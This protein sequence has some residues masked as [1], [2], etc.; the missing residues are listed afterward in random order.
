MNWAT[1][2]SQQLEWHWTHQLR[3]RFQGLTDAEYL[4][5]PVAGCWSVRPVGNGKYMADYQMPEPSPPPVTTIAW[6]LSHIAGPVLAWRNFNHFQ[7]PAFDI[8]T[9]E[10]PGTAEAALHLIDEGYARWRAGVESLGEERLTQPC[11]PAEGP[12]ADHSMAALGAAHQPRDDSSRRGG[13]TAARPL[14]RFARGPVHQLVA[15]AVVH[16]LRR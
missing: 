15:D 13:G 1:E 9:F 8:A 2:L 16:R 14:P 6:R 7:G 4:W 3:P 12:F 11:G 5:E 10:W